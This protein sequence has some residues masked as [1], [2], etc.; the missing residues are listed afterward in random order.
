MLLD[1]AGATRKWDLHTSRMTNTWIH[2]NRE[3]ALFGDACHP[4]HPYLSVDSSSSSRGEIR[5]AKTAFR[6]QG[7]AQAFEDAAVLGALFS[8]VQNKGQIGIAIYKYEQLR[9]PRATRIV[10]ESSASGI[11]LHMPDGEEQR[12][13]DRRLR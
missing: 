7:A 12:E 2:P 6:A 3:F 13:R 8:K 5:L 1:I 11:I 9:K 4:M 10:Q